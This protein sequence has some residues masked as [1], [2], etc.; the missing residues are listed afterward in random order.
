[1]IGLLASFAVL[2]LPPVRRR[3]T[4]RWRGFEAGMA[5]QITTRETKKEQNTAG[6]VERGRRLVVGWSLAVPLRG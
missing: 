6:G 3:L 4:G 1:L 5:S 2:G